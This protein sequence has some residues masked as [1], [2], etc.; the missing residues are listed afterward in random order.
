MSRLTVDYGIDLGTTNSS[1][2]VMGKNGPEVIRVEGSDYLPSAVYID[3]DGSFHVGRYA[4]KRLVSDPQNSA[5]KFKRWM[6]TTEQKNFLR[7]GLVMSAP[8]LSSE[9]LKTL[10]AA[11]RERGEED[12]DAVVVTVPADFD[13]PQS[14]ATRKAAQ[15][16][17][18]QTSHLLMEPVA[19]SLAYGFD[20]Q[21]NK[22]FWLVFDFGGGTFDAAV[23]RVRDGFIQIVNHGGDNYLGGT[24][25]DWLIVNQLF[26]PALQEHFNLPDFTS[27]NPRWI[28]A[29]AKL[30]DEAE[31]AKIHVSSAQSCNVSLERLCDDDSG[32]SVDFEFRLTRS[33]ISTLIEPLAKRAIEIAKRVLA[34]QKLGRDDIEKLILV[35]GPTLTPHLREML[36]DPQSGLAIP[37]DYSVDPLTV[38]ARGAALFAST[39]KRAVGTSAVH[40]VSKD[41]F[42]LQVEYK[43]MAAETEPLVG[44]KVKKGPVTNCDGYTI[45]FFNNEAKPAWR[46][47]KIRLSREGTFQATLWAEKGRRNTFAIELRD[48]LGNRCLTD[49]NELHYMVAV[50]PAGATLPHHIGVA[51]ADNK[52]D[53]FFKK[54]DSPP[55]KKKR[56]H[57][58]AKELRRGMSNQ[59]MFI[60]I[61]EGLDTED[62]DLNRA[63][64]FIELK[65][66]NIRRD[67]PLGSEVEITLEIDDSRILTGSAYIPLVDEELP[68]A[69]E[70]NLLKPKPNPELLQDDVARQQRRVQSLAEGCAPTNGS[71]DQER[72]NTEGV[73]A[74][75]AQVQTMVV[76]AH[77]ADDLFACQNQLQDLKRKLRAIERTVELPSLKADA[78]NETALVSEVV[79]AHGTSEDRHNWEL[80]KADILRALDDGNP[81]ILRRTMDAAHDLRMQL[82]VGQMWWWVGVHEY[83]ISQRSELSDQQ[84]ANRWFEHNQRALTQGDFEALK[85]GCR[86]LWALLPI[87]EQQRGYG[88]TT[89]R[90]T[91]PNRGTSSV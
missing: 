19:A 38:V 59:R 7:S 6:G 84:Q 68:L 73:K 50:E 66:Q 54:G 56:I 8:E 82:S 34:E 32:K 43:P 13:Q 40:P 37:L 83:L 91:T 42:L 85:S 72:I 64:G 69:F 10:V 70:G 14:H 52:M 1:I 61:V 35:G 29:F 47:G 77:N 33:H 57:A 87:E 60:P 16:A 48:S 21:S 24:D 88:G 62:A 28:R 46:S 20:H 86:N 58:T 31:T 11:A 65:A 90:A 9:V 75:L 41:T 76:N 81:D 44:G 55:L 2:A 49:P 63:I 4:K 26:I 74:A 89:I 18:I 22:V 17:G 5:A 39:Q 12:L 25:V 67:V 15:L 30:I 23:A 79:E 51:M 3:E 27:D 80:L 36:A 71:K 53:I 78:R 45:E